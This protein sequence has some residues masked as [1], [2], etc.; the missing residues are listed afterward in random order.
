MTVAVRMPCA[1]LSLLLALAVAGPALAVDPP[2]PLPHP[3]A[4]RKKITWVSYTW[5]RR[6]ANGWLFRCHVPVTGNPRCELI[7]GVSG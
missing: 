7:G 5:E 1:L 4:K 2:Q 6:L 3:S